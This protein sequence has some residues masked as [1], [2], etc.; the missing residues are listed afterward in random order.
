M[1]STF[2]LNYRLFRPNRITLFPITNELHS[3]CVAPF[4]ANEGILEP[5]CNILLLNL[6]ILWDL[7]YPTF[8]EDLSAFNTPTT[9]L[10]QNIQQD[11]LSP[12]LIP[13]KT[14][15][16]RSNGRNIRI[17]R[18]QEKK[19]STSKNMISLDDDS[20]NPSCDTEV[21]ITEL[22]RV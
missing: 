15:R 16:A 14:R 8:T 21:E 6:L 1:T 7:V 12:P 22:D 20:W 4:M 10:R 5:F 11:L 2:P 18:M 3:F 13:T 9:P 19:I 17:L